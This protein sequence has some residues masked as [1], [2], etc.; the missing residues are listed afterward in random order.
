MG[1][2]G[3]WSVRLKDGRWV[4]DVQTKTA[5]F[6]ADVSVPAKV[7]KWQCVRVSSAPGQPMT[8]ACDTDKAI[9]LNVPHDTYPAAPLTIGLAQWGGNFH[10]DPLRI[11]SPILYWSR[12]LT[13]AE[14][15]GVVNT[16]QA[17]FGF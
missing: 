2:G 13:D 6:T 4:L 1:V 11:R 5:Q 12:Q 10:G 15:A 16:Q 9:S 17:P 3:S 8:I 7:G 14:V